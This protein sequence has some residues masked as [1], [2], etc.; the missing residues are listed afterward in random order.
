MQIIGTP[1][2]SGELLSNVEALTLRSDR[3][4]NL[5]KGVRTEEPRDGPPRL[6]LDIGPL[7]ADN[8]QVTGNRLAKA[9]T[10]ALAKVP[11]SSA[12]LVASIDIE[13]AER[14][15]TVPCGQRGLGVDVARLD[16]FLA[17]SLAH[18]NFSPHTI[19][20]FEVGLGSQ[21]WAFLSL[22]Y[23]RGPRY[24]EVVCR[25]LR[26][27][28]RERFGVLLRLVAT[29][30]RTDTKAAISSHSRDGVFTSQL[31][32]TSDTGVSLHR[33]FRVGRP[34]AVP[35][36]PGVKD[37]RGYPFTSIDGAITRLIE[38]MIFAS[39]LSSADARAKGSMELRGAIPL[40]LPGFEALTPGV[41]LP[42]IGVR[43][44][45]TPGEHM[46]EQAEIQ[47]VEA[48]NS[49]ACEVGRASKIMFD[50]PSVEGLQAIGAELDEDERALHAQLQ[51]IR[52]AALILHQ[53]DVTLGAALPTE[54]ASSL[55]DESGQLRFTRAERVVSSVIRFMQEQILEWRDRQE[56]S[57]SLL[58]SRP[59]F[60]DKDAVK[61]ILELAAHKLDSL[62]DRK[63]R[64]AQLSPAT[65]L[66]PHGRSIVAQALIA[67]GHVYEARMIPRL[68]HDAYCNR[69]LY[70]LGPHEFSRPG[71]VLHLKRGKYGFINN[72]QVASK[73]IGLPIL[74]HDLLRPALNASVRHKN[75]DKVSAARL[76]DAIRGQQE[77]LLDRLWG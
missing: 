15:R 12:A 71:D 72:L 56:D 20:L 49:R 69:K 9:L 66:Y 38:D 29:P 4:L 53:R 70:L 32:A 13:P 27:D 26:E 50:L 25:Q 52:D 11:W 28:L 40:R 14:E 30:E 58:V 33:G 1:P 35:L 55:Q 21:R 37:W 10:G 6:V 34:L 64:S 45:L 46:I 8:D 39:R 36:A 73:L 16:D 62:G 77:L 61:R 41:T 51:N 42:V 63:I 43:A 23:S 76:G 24:V 65:L 22:M 68:L 74:G 2:A 60:S 5:I 47:L 59:T 54:L 3:F 17:E 18:L 67:G 19:T 31:A 48:R 44:V 57:P 7:R 75:L